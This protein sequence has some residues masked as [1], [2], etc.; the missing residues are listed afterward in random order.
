MARDLTALKSSL[1][2]TPFF[3]GLQSESL[4]LIMS[5]LVER[6]FDVGTLVFREGEPGRSMY[7]VDSGEL[8]MNQVGE[9]GHVV[10][11]MRLGPGDFFGETALIEIAPR[12]FSVVVEKPV[13]LY[14]LTNVDLY[15]LYQ[16]DV[17]A[18]IMVLQN[19]NRELCRRLRKAD[20]R[21]TEVADQFGYTTTQ[22]RRI[23][24]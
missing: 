6:F 12:S 20:S 9:S 1:M 17:Q 21:I 15:H 22:I 8:V 5:M 19:I 7:I 23:E 18:Y 10:R 16:R 3:G 14:E 2:H 24:K 4:D 11:L 13:Q